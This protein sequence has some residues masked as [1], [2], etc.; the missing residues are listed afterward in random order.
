MNK[1]LIAVIG[2]LLVTFSFSAFAGGRAIGTDF[3]KM[4][5]DGQ[6]V[7]N[8]FNVIYQRPTK[9]GK[10]IIFNLALGDNDN[11]MFEG[12]LKSYSAGLTTGVFNQLGLA[13]IDQRNG[14]DLG[15]SAALG[16]EQ[17]A[18]SNITFFGSVKAL[19]LP[20]NGFVYT[21]TLGILWS[22]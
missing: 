6:P 15:F 21:P 12:A 5:D 22:F 17:A 16:Y 11:V 8:S 14:S 1:G 9:T 10:T 7:G 20:N 2:S 13:L 19:F 4:L 18:A 3:I